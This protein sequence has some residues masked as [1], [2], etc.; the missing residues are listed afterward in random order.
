MELVAG[1]RWIF[2]VLNTD[3]TLKS[4]I[5]GVFSFPAPKTAGFPY[6]IFQD[7]TSTDLRGVGPIRIGLSGEWLIRAVGESNTY[8][9]TL[10]SIAD[11]VDS[12]LQAA[13]GSQVWSCVRLRPFRLVET[14]T[15]RQVRHLGGFYRLWVHARES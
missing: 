6:V 10:E 13:S 15:E 3:E 11:R 9:G 8:G 14:S 7:V 2:S 5:S 1:D 4:M 12:L